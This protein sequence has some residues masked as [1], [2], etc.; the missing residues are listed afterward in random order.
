MP[1]EESRLGHVFSGLVGEFAAR[2][3]GVELGV[4]D[5][6]LGSF[7]HRALARALARRNVPT[8]DYTESSYTTGGP[9]LADVRA[10]LSRLGLGRAP[11]IGGLW[12]KR[13]APPALVPVIRDMSP[14]ADG[15]FVFTTY[16]LWQTP[17]RLDGPYLLQAPAADYWRAL[18]QAN[19][20]P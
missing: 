20:T 4:F 11:L 5:L 19:T 16:S 14:A 17:A 9:A 7:V 1:Y 13:F 8:A 2:H 6:D 15:Y 12:L 3:P 18:R 10:R